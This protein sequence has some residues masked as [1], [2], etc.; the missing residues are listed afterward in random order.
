[1]KFLEDFR[2]QVEE[3]LR[4]ILT[5]GSTPLLGLNTM[6][7][8]H[9]GFCNQDGQPQDLSRGKYM[10]SLFCLAMCAALGGSPEQA[11]PAAASIELA[12]RTS[13]IFD[14]IQDKGRERN[15]RETVW[16]IWGANQAINAGVALSCYARLALLR[17]RQRKV[18]DEIILK[19]SS[20]LE[21]AVIELSWGQYM[22]MSFMDSS[23]VGVEDYQQMVRGKT[24]ALFGAACEVGA[25]IAASD[26]SIAKLARD[27]GINMGIAFQIHDDYL[28]VW[29]EEEQVGKTAN[30]LIEKKRSLPVVLALEMAPGYPQVD[31]YTVERWL[32]QEQVRPEEAAI[33]KA[34]MED[35]GIPEQVRNMEM[36]YIIA[37]R[38]KLSCL[39]VLP[40]WR[41]QFSQLLASLTKREL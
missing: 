14:D 32:K 36:L 17:M 25:V 29:G 40:Q 20:V 1:M 24:G 31:T 39:P 34:W 22:D 9:M 2:V 23:S 12:H 5:K 4:G 3:E 37:A 35:N 21:N 28:G 30:D 38:E 33:F 16:S 41:E 15:N 13:L 7:C 26:D 11:L 19:I 6:N 27:F 8:Y 18:P 10:R